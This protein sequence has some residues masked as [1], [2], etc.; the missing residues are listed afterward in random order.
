MN[1]A[2]IIGY[3]FVGKATAKSLGITHY[4]SRTQANVSLNNLHKFKYIFLCLPTP[5]V[6]GKQD[7]ENIKYYIDFISEKWK[8]NNTDG[9]FIIRSTVLPGTAHKIKQHQEV[10]IV[11]VPEFL[12]EDTWEQDAQWPDIIVV[13]SDNQEKREEVAGIFKARFKGAEY[14]L[15]D[16]ITA[17]TI[18]YGV[19]TFYALKVIFANQLF[20]FCDDRGV[21]YETVKNAMYARKWIGKN[22][23]EIWHKGGRGAGGKCLKKDLDAFAN[24][25]NI[26]LLEYV[27]KINKGLLMTHA[28]KR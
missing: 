18:K 19:N 11:H 14:F 12:S 20:D 1:E 16:S 10:D 6:E 22:H 9:V 4:Y 17:E 8:E 2:V 28:K 7:R 26:P 24:Y 15:T 3:G 21:N 13:G 23:L 25:T 27:N 5:T